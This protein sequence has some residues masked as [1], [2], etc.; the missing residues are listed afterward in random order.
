MIRLI[1]IALMLTSTTILGQSLS[2][3]DSLDVLF[4]S[5]LLTTSEFGIGKKDKILND[6]D[7]Q[8]ATFLKTAYKNF[9]FIKVNFSQKY[10]KL[11]RSV[12]MLKRPCSY[13]LAFSIKDSRFFKLGG[14]ENPDIDDFFKYLEWRE[15]QIFYGISGKE[16]KGIDI[17]CLKEY[18]ELSSKKRS[19]KGFN[20]FKNCKETT[21]LEIRSHDGKG[22]N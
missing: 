8:D 4:K 22:S 1:F 17:Y 14:F 15:K 10:F 5:K 16:V 12:S 20:C 18:F 2:K 7:N 11:D 9:V 21:E 6:I 13:Y 19:K 3:Q